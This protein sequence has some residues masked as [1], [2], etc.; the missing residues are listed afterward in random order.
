MKIESTSIGVV[1][2][3]KTE[4]SDYQWGQVRARIELDADRF[5]PE[6]LRGL[7][8]FSH[9]LVVFHFHAADPSREERGSRHPRENEDWPRVGIFAQRGKDRPNR[10]G[11]STCRLLDV[12]GL[13]LSVEGLDAI[14]DTPVLDIKPHMSGFTPRGPFREPDWA[15]EIM[16]DY[17]E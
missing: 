6:A 17:W 9:I 1:R 15:R 13:N 11:V 16:D 5:D 8:E 14:E 10:I 7:S 3:G 2:G 12:E 4:P